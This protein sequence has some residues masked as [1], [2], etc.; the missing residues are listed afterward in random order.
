[1]LPSLLQWA[2]PVKQA[3]QPSASLSNAVTDAASALGAELGRAPRQRVQSWLEQRCLQWYS[4]G[5][6]LPGSCSSSNCTPGPTYAS[7]S[8]QQR[9]A[10]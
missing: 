10:S 6:Q 2:G 8:S 1:M 5:L 9:G 4:V 7:T 3:V